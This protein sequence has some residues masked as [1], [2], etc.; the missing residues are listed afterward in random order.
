MYRQQRSQGYL[1]LSLLMLTSTVPLLSRAQE[2]PGPSTGT[3]LVQA[4]VKQH[5][6]WSDKISTPGASIRVKEI[7]REGSQTRYSFYF[8]GRPND[9]VYSVVSW[10][11]S[12][13]HPATLMEGVSLGKDGIV[14][15]TGRLEGE[16]TFVDG[17]E[18]AAVIVV[19]NPITASDKGCT[20][21][22]KRL[23]PQLKVAFFAGSEYP[24]MRKRS[25][26]RTRMKRSMKWKRQQTTRG[27]STSP[28]C[29]LSPAIYTA[30]PASKLPVR[31]AHPG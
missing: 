21:T 29:R 8:S 5:E 28:C 13:A 17:D 26:I 11:I 15:C 18:R 3:S 1:A 10:P 14:S 22:V 24:R 12:Q 30:Q 16:C 6:A 23:M 20:I 25:S 19:A 31:C 9:R 2:G 7:G 27:K 4:L